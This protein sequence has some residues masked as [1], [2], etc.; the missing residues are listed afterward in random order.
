M[1]NQFKILTA[2]LLIF[3]LASSCSKNTTTLEEEIVLESN[4]PTWL[5]VENG[6]LGE[7][8]VTQ[9]T[10]NGDGKENYQI[11]VSG[12]TDQINWE[13][14]QNGKLVDQA[15]NN[16]EFSPSISSE[17]ETFK[18]ALVDGP[19]VYNLGE[20]NITYR[21]NLD[22]EY[23]TFTKE[24]VL[25]TYNNALNFANNSN[26]PEVADILQNVA[27]KLI[28]DEGSYFTGQVDH[29]DIL[30]NIFD[31]PGSDFLFTGTLIHEACHIYENN[32][33]EVEER[34]WDFYNN[35]TWQHPNN[36]YASGRDEMLACSLASYILNDP[37]EAG[38]HHFVHREQYYQDVILA[39]F[40]ERFE[41]N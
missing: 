2:L 26:V 22:W 10:N 19:L 14:Y 17:S 20:T 33:P 37:N 1:K 16:N 8:T 35:A 15:D 39:Y 3:S 21:Y 23:K 18:V 41:T 12:N 36:Y 4:Y 27:V 11:L 40:R 25:R 28:S 29:G 24:K 30:L 5:T 7:V 31:V 13:F 38:G 32:H 9:I 6:D 34:M